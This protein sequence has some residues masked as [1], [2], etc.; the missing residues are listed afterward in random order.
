MI[1]PNWKITRK[2]LA[3]CIS[4]YIYTYPRYVLITTVRQIQLA[5]VL[6]RIFLMFILQE[7]P[8]SVQLLGRAWPNIVYLRGWDE[9][10]PRAESLRAE[11]EEEEEEG[12]GSRSRNFA[13]VFFLSILHFM[14]EVVL[15]W[16]DQISLVPLLSFI[17]YELQVINNCLA[18]FVLESFRFGDCRTRKL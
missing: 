10:M 6:I 14:V 12:Q 4:Y 5:M 3:Q 17:Y 9:L 11:V 7:Q 13:V 8:Y 2:S 18:P 1:F 15:G 16:S